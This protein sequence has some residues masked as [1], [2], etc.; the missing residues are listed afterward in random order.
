MKINFEEE[1]YQ[2]LRNLSDKEKEFLNKVLEEIPNIEFIEDLLGKDKFGIVVPP[3]DKFKENIKRVGHLLE[4]DP[5]KVTSKFSIWFRK[6]FI[7]KMALD[8]CP[9]DL[10]DKELIKVKEAEIPKDRP[11]IFA[12]NHYSRDDAA[13]GIS[14]A[15]I[16]AYLVFGGLPYFYQ[17]K[18]G[19]E[20][21]ANG[22][23]LINRK[24]KDSRKALNEKIKYAF[25]NGLPA[26]LFYPEASLN[27]SPNKLLLNYWNG[28]FKL[29]KECGAAIIPIASITVDN[30]IYSSRLPWIDVSEMSIDEANEHLREVIGT[31][32]YNLMEQY[33]TTTREDIL[34]DGLEKYKGITRADILELEKKYPHVAIKE[35]I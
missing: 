31:E 7:Y 4:N 25:E 16:L 26:V 35:I 34:L 15:R 8:N 18:V 17:S 6:K 5:E 22:S 33:A 12:P 13:I 32:I 27:K 23:I 9:K 29:A 10:G 19:F 2:R 1:K 14:M 21:W 20:A 24:N 30:K 3:S 11:L 28:I